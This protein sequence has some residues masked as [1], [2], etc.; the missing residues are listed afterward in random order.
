[1][2]ERL[3]DRAHQP[4]D[5]RIGALLP[6]ASMQH[7]VIHR[8][9]AYP[10]SPRPLQLRDL[11]PGIDRTRT[12]RGAVC[13]AVAAAVWALEQPLDKLVFSSRYDDVELLG[14]AL[15]RGDAWYPAGLALHM[16][17]G[18]AFGAAYAN[19]APAVPL[20]PALRGPAVALMQHL[21]FWPLG[22]VSDRFH[23]ARQELPPISGNRR[24]F[25]QSAWRHLVF[26]IVLGELERRVNATPEPA[27]PEP[28]ADFSSNGH[29]TLED[30]VTV[31]GSGSGEFT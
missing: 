12:L 1:M 4:V 19:L 7:F 8:T 21:A 28:E 31:S 9:L 17:N 10:Y 20:L 16:Q 5:E 15:T 23:P 25:A 14:K 24:A 6:G 27:P 26:G 2:E 11:S 30:A 18:A 22:A 29:G 13:G 3:E